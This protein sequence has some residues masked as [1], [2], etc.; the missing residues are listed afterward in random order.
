MEALIITYWPQL[1]ALVLFVAGFA[2]LQATANETSKDLAS[3]AQLTKEGF[4][5]VN[6]RLDKVNGRLD[7]SED[8]IGEQGE[9]IARLE[10]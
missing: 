9:R 2:R 7:K 4:E 10:R 6:A 1:A 8:K 5:Q 3:H